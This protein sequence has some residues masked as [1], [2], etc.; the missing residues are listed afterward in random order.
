MILYKNVDICDLKSILTKGILSIDEY[1]N[2]NWG[3][4]KRS[5][6]STSVV[7]LFSPIGR[8]NSFPKS[9]GVALLEIECEAEIHEMSEQDFHREDYIEYVTKKVFPSE[10]KKVIIPEVF[11]PYVKIQK[12]INVTWCQ[13]EAN[14]Y[15]EDE[16]DELKK[17]KCD[18]CVF[19]IF[20]ETAPLMTTESFNFFR[21]INKNNTMLDLY[22]IRYIY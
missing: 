9:Y 10:I 18:E 13:I 12:C 22:D 2:D 15:E 7:Y 6:N 4:G 11:K 16:F 17:Y 19:K 8:Q 20:A 1:G 5:D 3:E 21:G 14:Y